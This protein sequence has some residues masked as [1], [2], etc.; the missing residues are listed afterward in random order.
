MRRCGHSPKGA[1]AI[2]EDGRHVVPVAQ[3]FEISSIEE[4]VDDVPR[5]LGAL[6][7]LGR[8]RRDPLTRE[9]ADEL[10]DLA[11]LVAQRVDDHAAIV[12]AT[13]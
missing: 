1:P 4:E 10:A 8:P 5:K 3:T 12:G 6:V 2:A 11:L 9:R 7:D 13:W